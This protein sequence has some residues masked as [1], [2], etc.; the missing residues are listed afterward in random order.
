M[1]K[2]IHHRVKN[3][4]QIIS[5]LLKLQSRS[6]TDKQTL[7]IFSE[8]QSRIRTMALIHESLYQSND[9]SR[10][11]FAEYITKLVTNLFRSY[12]INSSNI[13][14]VVNIDDNVYLEIDIA[15][16]CGLIINELISNS[17]K[18]AFP[19]GEKGKIKIALHSSNER[20]LTLIVSDNGVGI[21]KDLDLHQ[22]KTL[23][24][25]L[26]INLVEQLEGD[27]KINSDN[28]TEFIITF[29]V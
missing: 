25:Q 11:N 19:W 20:D 7:S 6:I 28:G 18:Y 23:G 9:L 10:V 2:E 15:V 24:L 14:P 5:S 26:V 8:S 16:P 3:N 4:L 1:L 12:E 21:P 17:L 27:L 22:T 13:K 29:T